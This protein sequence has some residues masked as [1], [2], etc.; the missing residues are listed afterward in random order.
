MDEMFVG[1]LLSQLFLSSYDFLTQQLLQVYIRAAVM[2]QGQKEST[3]ITVF[4][5]K[6]NI[7]H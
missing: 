7:M 5:I 6:R 4:E 1:M 2:I 3:G